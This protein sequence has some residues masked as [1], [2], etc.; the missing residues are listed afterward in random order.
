MS[1][2]QALAL[3]LVEIL[4][5]VIREVVREELRAAGEESRWVRVEQAAAQLGLTPKAIYHR[6]ERGQLEARR[7]GRT[8]YIDT[9]HRKDW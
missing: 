6:V 5:P 8:L 1:A 2:E 3:S 4:R 7:L 9:H